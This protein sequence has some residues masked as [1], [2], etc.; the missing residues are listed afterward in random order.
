MMATL[1][2]KSGSGISERWS[3]NCPSSVHSK[4]IRPAGVPGRSTCSVQSPTSA[5]RR[6]SARRRADSVSFMIVS[7][8]GS[9]EAA[10]NEGDEAGRAVAAGPGE[11]GGHGEERGGDDRVDDAD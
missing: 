2:G 7:P 3:R 1:S 4:L 10:S 9:V 11:E 5:L 8:F 6:V